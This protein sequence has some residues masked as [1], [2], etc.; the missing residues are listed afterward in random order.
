M[1]RF[2]ARLAPLHSTQ[3][4]RVTI[5]WQKARIRRV[6]FDYTKPHLLRRLLAAIRW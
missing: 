4:L 3:S 2:L 6:R 5:T 1:T